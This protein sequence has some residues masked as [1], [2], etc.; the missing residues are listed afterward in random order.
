MKALMTAIQNM[1]PII[2]SMKKITRVQVFAGAAIV[3]G[4]SLVLIAMNINPGDLISYVF[5]ISLLMTGALFGTG[6]KFKKRKKKS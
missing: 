2:Q 3:C 4:L 6:A 5:V 1:K